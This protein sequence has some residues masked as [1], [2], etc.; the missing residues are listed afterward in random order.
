MKFVVLFLAVVAA[1]LVGL[2]TAA[3][4]AVWIESAAKATKN[5]AHEVKIIYGDYAEGAIEPT[6]K[7]YSD[8]KTL[9]VWVVS[10]SQQ[11]TKLTLTDAGTHLTASF[12]PEADGLYYVT[13]VH[14]TKELGGTTKYEFSSVAPVLVG[15][16]PP[17][18]AAP[19]SPL[20]IVAAPKAY[21]AGAPV[22]AQVW[23]AGQPFKNGKV[24]LM[25]PEGWVKTVKTDAD[26]KVVFTPKLKGT[27]VLEAS[28]YQEQA[29]EWH[30]KPYTHFWQGSTTRILIN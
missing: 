7:W 3:A 24:E 16:A 22:E 8:L 30:Q 25:S 21:K 26:G 12:L 15:S 17:A 5:K 10:P 13:T 19:A 23:K 14:A 20:A 11:K 4:H 18:L 1:Y 28:D 29:G 9:E 2:P 27:Y 6:A